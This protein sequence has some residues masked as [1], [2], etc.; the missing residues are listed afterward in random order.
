MHEFSVVQALL[1]RV[2][3]EARARAAVAVNT[4]SV[5]LGELSGVNEELL[6][7]AFQM[8][9]EGTL[10]GG[11]TLELERVPVRWECRACARP[12]EQGEV[13]RCPDCDEP[14][15]LAAG[16]E[17]ILQQIEMEVP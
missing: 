16:D 1:Q 11:A 15:R 4:I 2:E 7:S 9:R 6:A 14:V 5:R 8:C 13:L 17:L 12:L 3:T 10:C